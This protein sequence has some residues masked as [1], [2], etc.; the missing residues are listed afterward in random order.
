[1]NAQSNRAKHA[2]ATAEWPGVPL[3]LRRRAVL[4][5]LMNTHTHPTARELYA[6]VRKLLPG[7]SLATVYNSL[8]YLLRLGLVNEHHAGGA[9]ARYCVNRYPHMHLLDTQNGNMV[10]IFLKP[11]VK[12]ED[13]FDLPEGA[14]ITSIS[15]YL[16]GNMGNK[17]SSLPHS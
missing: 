2:N 9:A 14:H 15:A 10:D 17:K 7:I 5:A 8:A 3:T 4:D 12:A 11:G 13:V 1:M 6:L 16:Y